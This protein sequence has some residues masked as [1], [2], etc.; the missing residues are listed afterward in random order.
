MAGDLGGKLFIQIVDDLTGSIHSFPVRAQQ[1][2]A[3]LLRKL[4][5]LRRDL[6][7]PGDDEGGYL[8]AQQ[9]L[10]YLSAVLGGHAL[11]EHHLGLA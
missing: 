2:A 8:A 7:V 10:Q 4:Q 11:E 5:Q 6:H 9:I 1:S 3:M